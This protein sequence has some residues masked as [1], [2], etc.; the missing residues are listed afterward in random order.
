MVLPRVKESQTTTIN[1]ATYKP[2]T[3]EE[4]S[5]PTQSTSRQN[6]GLEAF[7]ALASYRQV[8]LPPEI[9]DAIIGQL[10]DDRAA[11]AT[12]A[13]VCRS[14][15]PAS[16]HHLFS[17]VT[18]RP[19]DL[20]GASDLLSSTSCTIT[21][22]VEYLTL[23][24]FNLFRSDVWEVVGKLSRITRLRLYDGGMDVSHPPALAPLLCNLEALDLEDV[25]FRESSPFHS[26]LR[27]CPH[28]RHLSFSGLRFR[29]AKHLSSTAGALVPRLTSLSVHPAPLDYLVRDW[30]TATSFPP[31]VKLDLDLRYSQLEPS[32][33]TLFEGVGQTLQELNLLHLHAR[34]DASGEWVSDNTT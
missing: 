11:L 21:S 27:H 7:T 22:A 5:Y 34:R 23:N 8:R 6:Q 12:C 33:E 2:K 25:Y 19:G 9:M 4:E 31:L 1:M 32:I 3:M 14:W 17:K 29:T 15:V 20:S 13:L 24:Q 28:L 18:I 10:H 30:S 16:R 26:L